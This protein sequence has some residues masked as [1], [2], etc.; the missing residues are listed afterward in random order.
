MGERLT[1]EHEQRAYDCARMAA[2]GED[3]HTKEG[4]PVN[5]GNKLKLG[6]HYIFTISD[7]KGNPIETNELDRQVQRAVGK[8]IDEAGQLPIYVTPMQIFRAFPGNS[9]NT[10]VT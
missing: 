3:T 5:V 7:A 2:C 4:V 8:L 10:T 6:E 1:G 9:T